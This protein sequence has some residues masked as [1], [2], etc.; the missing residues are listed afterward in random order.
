MERFFASLLPGPNNPSATLTCADFEASFIDPGAQAANQ[1]L[2]KL[3]N[4]MPQALDRPNGTPNTLEFTGT[5]VELNAKKARIL[6]PKQDASSLFG[7]NHNASLQNIKD[8]IHALRTVGTTLAMMND[9]RVTPLFER[10]QSRLKAYMTVVD[11]RISAPASAVTLS[12]AGFQWDA[13]FESWMKMYLSDRSRETWTW[14]RDMMG[15]VQKE[16]KKMPEKTQ[17]EKDRKAQHQRFLYEF[18][19]SA[20]G[21]QAHYTIRWSA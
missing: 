21:K 5:S 4:L 1:P 13:A 6:T 3:Y 15:E 8:K 18:E 16:I 19:K 20:F 9:N 12:K 17:A 2:Q 14:V 7:F 11:S 10:A